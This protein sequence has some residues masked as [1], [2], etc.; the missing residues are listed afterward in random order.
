MY[1]ETINMLTS[2]AVRKPI[3]MNIDS[4]ENIFRIVDVYTNYE[5]I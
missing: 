1:N 2:I 3:S 5:T 4:I